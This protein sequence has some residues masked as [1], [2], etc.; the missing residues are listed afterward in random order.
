MERRIKNIFTF[1]CILAPILL[2]YNTKGIPWPL[3]MYGLLMPVLLV[4]VHYKKIK[5]ENELLY[6]FAYL[7]IYAAMAVIKQQDYLSIIQ[8]MIYI[9]I[10]AIMPNFLNQ[11]IGLKIYRK[12][13][14][15][16]TVVALLQTIIAEKFH[17]YLSGAL[18]IGNSEQ[19]LYAY[20]MNHLGYINV[21][22]VRARSLF[23]EP[24]GYAVYV[25]LFLII[26]LW[27]YDEI[28]KKFI[29][30]SLFLSV[31]IL[32]ARSSTGILLMAVGWFGFLLKNIGK[33]KVKI[34]CFILL[35]LMMLGIILM[36]SS[37]SFQIFLEH[38]F[39]RGS[40]GTTGRVNGYTYVL[41]IENYSLVELI[42]GHGIVGVTTSE[43][44]AIWG[45]ILYQLGLF[46]VAVWAVLLISYWKRGNARQRTV[47]LI[48]TVISAF[49][50]SGIYSVD[51]IWWWSIYFVLEN[52]SLIFL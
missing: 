11:K 47:I 2:I 34:A 20:R 29:V 39:S 49:A 14:Y 22:S 9:A 43:F 46:G 4:V 31:G 18:P 6:L 40:N 10:M 24:S 23:N 26:I 37:R 16:S 42:F 17:Y 51:M 48:V 50:G 28:D 52:K 44:V 35:V 3:Y 12:I 5:I 41:N 15:I 38:T 7:C 13:C 30:S 45:R 8:K 32:V 33:R 36:L 1:I 25:V 19:T 21:Y 27:F